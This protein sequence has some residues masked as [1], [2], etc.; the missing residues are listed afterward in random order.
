MDWPRLHWFHIACLCYTV[1]QLLTPRHSAWY[2]DVDDGAMVNAEYGDDFTDKI[3]LFCAPLV[4]ILKA[5]QSKGVKQSLKLPQKMTRY[6]LTHW[7]SYGVRSM[8]HLK[9]RIWKLRHSD[10]KI[11]K[12]TLKTRPKC[13]VIALLMVMVTLVT[14]SAEIS[15]H[16]HRP[17]D[18][19]TTFGP[20][21]IFF[22]VYRTLVYS[23]KI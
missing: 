2:Y 8:V 16:S 22:W 12:K 17:N 5:S 13:I 3:T 20:F 10:Y 21:R 14:S 9:S 1:L 15:S 11:S 6:H 7:I 19:H 4:R 23:G 18:T